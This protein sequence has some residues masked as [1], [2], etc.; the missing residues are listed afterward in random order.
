MTTQR[1]LIPGLIVLLIAL[2][3]STQAQTIVGLRAGVHFS[4]VSFTDAGGEHEHTGII[5]RVQAGLTV[6]IPLAMGLYLQ[7]AA[8]Y[9]GKGFKQDGGW[10]ADADNEFQAAVSYVE[11]PLNLIYK[12]WIGAGNLVVGAGPYVGYGIGGTWEAE[13]N[14][15]IGDVV[16]AESRGDV[17]FKNDVADGEYGSYLY[18]KPWDYGANVVV[19]YQFSPKLTLQLQGQFGIANLMPE[20]DGKE[21]DG[22]IRNNGYGLTIGYG[23]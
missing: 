10:L 2:S 9:V 11:V 15:A 12:L 18:G 23:F 22:S 21:P 8:M 6:D 5:P 7:P 17:I 16:L 1:T 13:G 20:V 14:V 19:G 4:S 3:F